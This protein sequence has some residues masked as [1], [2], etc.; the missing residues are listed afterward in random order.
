MSE[1]QYNNT[2]TPA[3]THEKSKWPMTIFILLLFMVAGYSA[4]NSYGRR[5]WNESFICTNWD[6][7]DGISAEKGDRCVLD[8]CTLVKTE[9]NTDVHKCVCIRN[10][11]TVYRKCTDRMKLWRYQP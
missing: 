1:E 5:G 6:F 2:T 10:N 3:D 4:Y 9:L 7:F 11:E 8:N